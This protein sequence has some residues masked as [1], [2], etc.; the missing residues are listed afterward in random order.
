[1]RKT[2][3]F[4]IAVSL[5]LF[6]SATTQAADVAIATNPAVGRAGGGSEPANGIRLTISQGTWSTVPASLCVLLRISP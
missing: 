1:M 2:R 3:A 4:L 6:A 5:L